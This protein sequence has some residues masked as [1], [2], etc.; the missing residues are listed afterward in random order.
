MNKEA[1]GVLE[2][3]FLVRYESLVWI[4]TSDRDQTVWR[5]LQTRGEWKHTNQYGWQYRLSENHYWESSESPR[6]EDL[7]SQ[8]KLE[9]LTGEASIHE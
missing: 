4:R 7:F 5:S 8:C 2:S 9:V 1:F 3:K 6:L